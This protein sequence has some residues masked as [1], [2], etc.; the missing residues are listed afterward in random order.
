MTMNL[1]WREL[2]AHR[3]SLIVWC[4]GSILIVLSGMNKYASLS[5]TGQSMNEL[6]ADMPKSMQAIMG[7]GVFDLSKASG[8]YGILYLYLLMMAT[9]HAAMIGANIIAKEERDKT[10]EFLFVKPISR[11]IIITAKLSAAFINILIFNGITFLSSIFI[12]SKYSKGE[13]GIVDDI[14]ILMIGMFILQ[15]LFMMIGSGF[16]AVMKNPKRASSLS[17]G[18]LLLTFVLSIVIDLNENLEILKYF[19]PFKYFE[20]KN[21]MYGGG[22]D[23]IFVFLSFV[24]I[25]IMTIITYVTFQKR[26]LKV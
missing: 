3:K 2:K 20:A 25:V 6:M 12:V 4:I 18:I 24:F 26:D 15:L 9:I 5:G 1:F 13:E 11:Q 17:T 23:V 19:T 14:T 7:S 21:M 16:A 10:S 8:Y 22:F